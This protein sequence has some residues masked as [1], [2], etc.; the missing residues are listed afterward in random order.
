MSLELTPEAKAF[1]KANFL[2]THSGCQ[3]GYSAAFVLYNAGLS[4][5]STVFLGQVPSAH[6][7]PKVHGKVI[8]ADVAF[9][10]SVLK[11]IVDQAD[12]V[13]YLDHHVT[14]H[15]EIEKMARDNPKLK[16][17]Y[18]V[19]KCGSALAWEW[20]YGE[21][22]RMPTF[23]VL[24]QDSDLGLWS[25]KNTRYYTTA[26]DVEF[27]LILD[28]KNLK[29]MRALLEPSYLRDM[30]ERGKL[31]YKYRDRVVTSYL[32]YANVQMWNG[33]KVAFI[34]ISGPLLGE[35]ATRLAREGDEI[36]F[37]AAYHFN[38]Q[39]GTWIYSLRSKAVNVEQ[40]AKK[41]GGGGHHSA[42]A[43]SSRISPNELIKTDP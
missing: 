19:E 29:K 8:I 18:K 5:R 9:K 24:I 12:E 27:E 38:Q 31:Y 15:I 7:A 36:D 22:V 1:G 35:V 13:V 6:R 34:N 25:K 26:F 16:V 30:I 23:L 39:R 4:D 11:D 20:C 40:I 32:S 43:F 3:D 17:I 37:V 33:F 28:T 21:H 10:P 41:R 42:A 14:H 2:L